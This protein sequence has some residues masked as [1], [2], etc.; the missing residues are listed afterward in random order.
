MAESKRHL[1]RVADFT[2]QGSYYTVGF[3]TPAVDCCI[4]KKPAADCSL[5]VITP[6]KKR[7]VLCKTCGFG[8]INR[9]MQEFKAMKFCLREEAP[10]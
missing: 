1:T 10:F 4:C 9:I 3:W 7:F 6:K 5:T 8:H 2:V